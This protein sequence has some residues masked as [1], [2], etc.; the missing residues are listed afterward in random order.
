MDDFPKAT[1]PPDA[2]AAAPPSEPAKELT[3]EQK[4]LGDCK[5]AISR[6]TTRSYF[7]C[8]N[9]AQPVFPSVLKKLEDSGFEVVYSDYYTTKTGHFVKMT[10]TD[11][12]LRQAY[13]DETSQKTADFLSGTGA[14]QDLQEGLNTLVNAFIGPS[15]N[16]SG[17]R[18]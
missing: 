10:I 8:V 12:G 14:S 16:V 13:T 17:F 6:L 15:S 18:F 11:P 1:P 3:P 7:C 9:F 5:N 2:V 4:Q